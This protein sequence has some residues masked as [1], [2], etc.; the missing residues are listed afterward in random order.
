M[1]KVESL[2]VNEGPARS[3]NP[4]TQRELMGCPIPALEREIMEVE[5]Q[6]EAL[7]QRKY[8]LGIALISAVEDRMPGEVEANMVD[9]VYQPYVAMDARTEN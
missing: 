4:D 9:G 6:I 8:D 3:M 2:K 5:A 7:I 1:S